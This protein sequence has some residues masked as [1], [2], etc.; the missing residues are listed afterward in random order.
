M[1]K[2]THNFAI[3]AVDVVVLSVIDKTLKV[4]LLKNQDDPF[5]NFLTLPGGLV[6]KSETLD[7]TMVRVLDQ[8]V[9]VQHIYCEQLYTFGS[10]E[11]DPRNRVVSVAYLALVSPDQLLTPFSQGAEWISVHNLPPLAYDHNEIIESAVQRVKAKLQYS[12]IAHAFLPDKF[13]LSHLQSLYEIILGKDLDKRNFR[14][15]ILSLGIIKPTAQKD[16]SG[17]HRPARLYEFNTKEL[18]F[19]D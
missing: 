5:K 13:R 17:S 18:V 16:I 15:K 11:R 8:R 19:Y 7:Q 9:N 10:L 4:L 14:K 3:I 2:Q 12:N 1:D 6:K